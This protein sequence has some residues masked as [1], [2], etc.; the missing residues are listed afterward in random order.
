[1]FDN[2]LNFVYKNEIMKLPLNFK[3]NIGFFINLVKPGRD[4]FL[5]NRYFLDNSFIH[6]D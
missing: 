2:N 1:M 3:P 5:Y 6:D 4:R